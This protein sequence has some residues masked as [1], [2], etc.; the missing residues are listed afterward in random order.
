[1]EQS[2]LTQSIMKIHETQSSDESLEQLQVVL[3]R[4]YQWNMWVFFAANTDNEGNIYIQPTYID[5][6]PLPELTGNY[7]VSYSDSDYA[8]NGLSQTVAATSIRRIVKVFF[9]N[10]KKDDC[11]GIVFNPNSEAEMIIP[12][13][14]IFSLFD[15]LDIED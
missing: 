2:E 9:D 13:Q 5:N 11:K 15:P 12:Y 4:L 7:L 14:S 6:L 3:K 1:M 10:H 8:V